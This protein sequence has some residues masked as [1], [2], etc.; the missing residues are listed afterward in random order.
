[1]WVAIMLVCFNPSALSCE[2]RAKSESFY[3]EEDCKK[4]AEA[5]AASM[6]QKNVYAVPACFKVGTSL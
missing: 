4:E 5:V 3:S 1:M 2:V 6:L